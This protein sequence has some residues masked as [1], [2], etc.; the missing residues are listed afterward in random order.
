[1]TPVSKFF[2]KKILIPKVYHYEF[3]VLID[4]HICAEHPWKSAY[5]RKIMQPIHE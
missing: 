2:H 1:M 5:I 4:V 3:Y